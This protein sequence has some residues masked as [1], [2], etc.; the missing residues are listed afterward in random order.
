M[1]IYLNTYAHIQT[2]SMQMC[3]WIH[4]LCIY[5]YTHIGLYGSKCREIS[6]IMS[7]LSTNEWSLLRIPVTCFAS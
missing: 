5:I 3:A 4:I 1:Y 6:E 2:H 7:G